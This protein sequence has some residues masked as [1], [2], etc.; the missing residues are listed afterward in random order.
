[1]ISR[2]PGH[3]LAATLVLMISAGACSGSPATASSDQASVNIGLVVSLT[4]SSSATAEPAVQG[5]VVALAQ[6]N[7]EHL[8]GNRQVRF[9]EANDASSPGAAGRACSQ[10]VT[11][12][13]VAAIVGFE[14]TA[15]LGACNQAASAAH[16]PYFAA[17]PSGAD[18]CYPNVFVFSFTPNQQVTPLID[19]LFRKQS[20]KTFYILATDNPLARSSAR[21]AALRIHDN[22]DVLLG[23]FFLPPKTLKY[24]SEIARIAAAKPDVVVDGLVGEDQIAYHLQFRSN[25]RVAGIKEASLQLDAATARSIGPAAVGVFV[26]QDYN[27]ADTSPAAQAWLTAL[28]KKF[29]D[30]AVPSSF[31]AE[32]YDA[33]LFMAMAMGH[34]QN[35][36]GEAIASAASTV[37]FEGP[38]GPIQLVSGAH[39]YA[40]V[41]AHIGRVNSTYGIDQVDVSSA[42]NPL[43]CQGA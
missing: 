10:L 36:S 33:T 28:M 5:A 15:A 20:A 30:G 26:A 41:S 32:M 13:H 37:S 4:G 38:R 6:A 19:F 35:T 42:V 3:L 40:T 11:Q 12:D 27:S 8:A 16:I 25:P 22:G 39:G 9:L 24:G 34:A 7:A 23:T 29:G 18:L 1:M 21:L 17:I 31:G 14:S 43:A 2:G